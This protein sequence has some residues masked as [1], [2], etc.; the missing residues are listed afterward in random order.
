M[1]YVQVVVQND[2]YIDAYIMLKGKDNYNLG[3]LQLSY[4]AIYASSFQLS[5]ALFL[6][7][8]PYKVVLI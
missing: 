4:Q 3:Q 8:R 6:S 1:S 7:D 2:I 5:L